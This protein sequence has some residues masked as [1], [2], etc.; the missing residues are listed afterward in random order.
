MEYLELPDGR[1]LLA[2]AVASLVLLKRLYDGVQFGS[3]LPN[4]GI[5]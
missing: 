4:T 2:A 1:R 3:Q 5:T